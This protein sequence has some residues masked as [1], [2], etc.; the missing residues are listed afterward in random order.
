[1]VAPQP[2]M[3]VVQQVLPSVPAA[4]QA[5]SGDVSKPLGGGDTGAA[6]PAVQQEAAVMLQD[7]VQHLAVQV[8]GLQGRPSFSVPCQRAT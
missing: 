8:R 1:M 3:T 4:T 6:T 7:H 2:A 5:L